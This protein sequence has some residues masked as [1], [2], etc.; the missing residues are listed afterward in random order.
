MV[1]AVATNCRGALNVGAT[2]YEPVA[3]CFSGYNIPAFNANSAYTCI[4]NQQLVCS[5][6]ITSACSTAT[7]AL[8]AAPTLI[9]LGGFESGNTEEWVLTSSS[10]STEVFN[11]AVS[12]EN[13]H[14]GSYSLRA[15]FSNT[16]GGNIQWGRN[17][18]GLSPGTWEISWWW[19]SNNAA[20]STTSR[21][22][23]A[24]S[25][26]SAGVFD[27]PTKN[28]PVGQ[29]VYFSRTFTATASTARFYMTMYGN[30]QDAGNVFYVDDF[31]LKKLS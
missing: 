6:T 7:E 8:G 26:T 29:W 16:G 19:Y 31:L 10:G 4:S 13:A 21:I 20:A 9:D 27:A 11:A 28:N 22:Q 25:G 23:I 15:A 30:Q 12:T 2:V 18:A 1:T 14:T 3:T 5:S 17:I 24:M